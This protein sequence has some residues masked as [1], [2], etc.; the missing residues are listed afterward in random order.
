VRNYFFVVPCLL[1]SICLAQTTA[2]IIQAA[3]YTNPVAVQVA[4]GQL[5]TLFLDAP[6]G[7]TVTALYSTGSD[8]PMPVI[9]V[10]SGSPNCNT[11]SICVQSLAVTVQIPFGIPT[12]ATATASPSGGIALV[13]N[14]VKTPYLPVQPL[15]DHVHILTV[16]DVSVGGNLAIP[17]Y[18]NGLP[19]HPLVTHADGTT[20]AGYQP[21][22]SGEE[23]VAYATG[24]GE[25][26]PAL[27]AGPPA[28]TSS[29]TTTTFTLD[30]NYHVN[31]LAAMPGSSSATSGT[32][33]FAGATAGFIGLYQ[34]NFIVPPPPP[35][36]LECDPSPSFSILFNQPYA[37]SNLTVSFGSNF[38]FDGV[39]ICVTPTGS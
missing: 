27:I 8:Q 10:D 7:S 1:S 31:A 3:G 26:S 19:C 36:T 21:A 2:P 4:P 30:F 35:G 6:V 9:R 16:C 14:G 20:V 33:V 28:A 34:I 18:I 29:P 12:Y 38:S 32:P 11:I 39:G 25:T 5:L 22:Q 13:I 15:R 17:P 24:L 23:L 37:Q